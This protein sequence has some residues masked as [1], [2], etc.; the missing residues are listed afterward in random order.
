[1]PDGRPARPG[2]APHQGL[3]ARLFNPQLPRLSRGQSGVTSLSV[4]LVV[5]A[6]LL[7]TSAVAQMVVYY[8]ASNLATAA[9]EEAARE[10]Q[11]MGGTADAGRIRGE[12]FVASAGPNLILDAQVSVTRGTDTVTAEVTGQAPQVIP[13]V[14][15]TIRA[16]STG[17]TERYTG[18]R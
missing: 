3:A 15:M 8:H 11:L 5:P 18:D 13:G 10:A 1:M 9:A 12:D 14:S 4:V 16:R 7:M 2:P 6:V 17:P